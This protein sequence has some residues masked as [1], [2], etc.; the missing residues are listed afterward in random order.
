MSEEDKEIE[1]CVSISDPA[2]IDLSVIATLST[3]DDTAKGI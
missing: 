3:S 1:V 2:V